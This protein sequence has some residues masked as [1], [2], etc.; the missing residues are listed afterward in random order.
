MK[1]MVRCD[2]SPAIGGGHVT[3]CLALAEALAEAGW[4]VD[5]AGTAGTPDMVPAL[6]R[7]GFPVRVLSGAGDEAADLAALAGGTVDLLVIDHYGREK[8][9]ETACRAFARRILVLDDGTGRDHDCDVLL[10]AAAPDA[11]AYAGHVPAAARILAGPAY[12]LLRGAFLECRRDSLAR[13]DGRPVGT[14]LV[15]FGA[16][17]PFNAT[18]LALAALEGLADD[19]T[20]TVALSSK[21]PHLE[22]IRRRLSGRT[23]LVLDGDMPLLLAEADLA[24]GAAGASAHERAALGLPSILVIVAENQRGVADTLFQAGAAVDGGGL[25]GGFPDRLAALA[26]RLIAGPEER[27][28][29]AEKAAALVDGRGP[30]RVVLAL[31][32]GTT[33]PDGSAVRLRLADKGDEAWLLAL[34]RHPATR[35]YAHNP[36]PPTAEEHARWLHRTLLDEDR[37]LFIAER[38]G[39]EA[40]MLR[41]DRCE[42][43]DGSESYLVSIAIDPAR[44]SSGLGTAILAASRRLKPAAVLEAEILPGNTASTRLFL[45]AGFRPVGEGR[46]R[47]LPARTRS[48]AAPT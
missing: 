26:R 46:Y 31:D 6:A 39:Q 29:L 32:D 28:R 37:F 24:I 4:Q 36:T 40:G 17:D 18:P 20:L 14:I 27:I 9:F 3:R 45:K 25:D 12:A 19:I 43:G 7:S 47:A 5:F 30:L 21:A 44:H 1:A 35:R 33:L 23:R 34:Q 41:L 8:Q 48:A 10:D 22:D 2:A 38:D 15:S 42:G 11:A 13:R 16:T